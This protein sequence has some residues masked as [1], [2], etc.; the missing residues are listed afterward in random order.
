MEWESLKEK[1]IE[2]SYCFFRTNNGILFSGNSLEVLKQL[3]SES[4]DCV[5]TSPPY[6]NLRD[7]SVEGQIGLE[8]DFRDYIEKL[9]S[10]FDEVH[11]ILKPTGTLWVNLGDTYGGSGMG[12]SKSDK[13]YASKETYRPTGTE[14][15]SAALR[16]TSYNKS[17]LLIPE[18][19]AIAMV[20]KGWKLRNK[21]I[22]K[23]TNCI[24]ESVKDRFTKSYEYIYF[25]VKSENYYFKQQF[26]PVKETSVKR[27]Q[28]AYSNSHKYAQFDKKWNPLRGMYKRL[29]NVESFSIG[30]SWI[31]TLGN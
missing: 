21:I 14:S 10:I 15:R 2:L 23:K 20:E 8:A 26:E 13:R 18:R 16:R 22:W 12:T 17:L 27:L 3:P 31:A 29:G 30:F 19:F 7:Y 6:W 24:P 9:L 11:R 25:F 5:V 28:R 1:L 4:V